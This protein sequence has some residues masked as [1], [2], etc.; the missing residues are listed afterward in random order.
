MLNLFILLLSSLTLK[1]LPPMNI[2]YKS[3]LN[4]PFV[5][6]QKLYLKRLENDKAY[7]IINGLVKTNGYIYYNKIQDN[8]FEY[9]LDENL[10][11]ILKKY[12]VSINNIDYDE[13][14]DISIVDIKINLLNFKKKIEF[15]KYEND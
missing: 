13:K 15:I 10:I 9:H 7:L 4:I 14:N 5:G 3:T 11:N 12:K 6:T 2:T 1:S 8:T